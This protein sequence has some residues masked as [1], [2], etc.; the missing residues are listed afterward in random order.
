M[1]GNLGNQ[2]FVRTAVPQEAASLRLFLRQQTNDLF[3]LS[4]AQFVHYINTLLVAEDAN[5][6]IIGALVSWQSPSQYNTAVIEA[7]VIRQDHLGTGVG[8]HLLARCLAYWQ[9]QC[10]H[11]VQAYYPASVPAYK[12]WFLQQGFVEDEWQGIPQLTMRQM[13]D[14]ICLH[15]KKMRPR[16]NT[17][18]GQVSEETLFQ[19]FQEG[20]SIWGTYSGG[21]VLRGILVGKMTPNRNIRFHYLQMDINGQVYTGTSQST[22]EFTNDGRIVLYEDWEWTGNRTG[23]GSSIIEEVKE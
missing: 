1:T 14:R 23:K 22:T 19:Y 12:D 21:Q 16:M 5:K 7:L 20:D 10:I 2:V 4:G 6:E 13:P 8:K 15:N 17:E 3:Q 18:N 11:K 9:N